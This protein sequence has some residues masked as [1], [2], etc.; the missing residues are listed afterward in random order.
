MAFEAALPKGACSPYGWNLAEI[1]EVDA[2]DRTARIWLW[3]NQYG[4]PNACMSR[5]WWKGSDEFHVEEEKYSAK[6][7]GDPFRP[8]L[9]RVHWSRIWEA[10]VALKGKRVPEDMQIKLAHRLTE[11]RRRVRRSRKGKAQKK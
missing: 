2:G 11:F 1:V 6:S 5:V 7:P 3:N 10:N 8:F 9:D 4:S